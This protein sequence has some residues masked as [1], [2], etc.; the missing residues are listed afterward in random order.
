VCLFLKM[1]PITHNEKNAEEC[2]CVTKGEIDRELMAAAGVSPYLVLRVHF[3]HFP[4]SR[5]SNAPQPSQISIAALVLTI[6]SGRNRCTHF[7]FPLSSVCLHRA[8]SLS[9]AVCTPWF[10]LCQSLKVHSKCSFTHTHTHTHSLLSRV[11]RCDECLA[12]YTV[13]QSHPP[14]V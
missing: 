2:K 3:V 14:S 1:P 12:N 4:P 6:I 10:S 8:R 13:F 9:L 5:V 11:S 7:I